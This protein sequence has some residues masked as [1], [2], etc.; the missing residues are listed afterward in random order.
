MASDSEPASR[1]DGN[2][3]TSRRA[4]KLDNVSDKGNVQR[5]A[6]DH[7]NVSFDDG[8]SNDRGRGR[9]SRK[10][11]RLQ[12]RKKRGDIYRSKITQHR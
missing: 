8:E 4:V 7:V 11:P 3:H 10:R 2:V 1:T 6:D 5:R 9:D 12:D